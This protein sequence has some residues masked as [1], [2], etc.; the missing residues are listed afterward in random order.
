MDQENFAKIC[1]QFDQVLRLTCKI[2]F[3]K[4]GSVPD[5]DKI[6]NVFCAS[7]VSKAME[8]STTPLEQWTTL[9]ETYGVVRDID[10]MV[11]KEFA[12]LKKEQ[13]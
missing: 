7:I 4:A 5:T 9:L 3:V 1:T 11:A 13:R 12:R 6:W 2:A 8:A 10:R